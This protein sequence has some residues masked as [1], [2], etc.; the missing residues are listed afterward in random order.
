MPIIA[1]VSSL[2]ESQQ[3]DPA[4]QQPVAVVMAGLTFKN[5]DETATYGQVSLP[6]DEVGADV[7][8]QDTLSVTFAPQAGGV[9]MSRGEEE[10]GGQGPQTPAPGYGQSQQP[11]RS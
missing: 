1:Y 10:H 5:E 4:T 2:S 11:R 3:Y 7:Q 9:G 6:R 8:F